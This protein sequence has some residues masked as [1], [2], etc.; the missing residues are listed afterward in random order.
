MSEL[1]PLKAKDDPDELS[2]KMAVIELQFGCEMS[3]EDKVTMLV[4]LGGAIYA[5][6]IIRH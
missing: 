5:D 2:D 1:E 4:N 6:T 3:E